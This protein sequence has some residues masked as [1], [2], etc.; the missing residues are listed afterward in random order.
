VLVVANR[1]ADEADLAA[2]RAVLGE[3]EIAV[4]PEDDVI[5]RA[6]AEGVA[7]IDL[8]DTSPGVRAI[9]AISDRLAA[10]ALPQAA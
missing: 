1:V 9:I 5:R 10:E 4:V 3:H 7:A 2:I 6:D 8:D